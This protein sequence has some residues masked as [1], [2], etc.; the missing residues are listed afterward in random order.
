MK[1]FALSGTTAGQE[2]T[3]IEKGSPCTLGFLLHQQHH[4]LK[5]VPVKKCNPDFWPV[6]FFCYFT[7]KRTQQARHDTSLLIFTPQ[8]GSD[9]FL[10]L[11]ISL[12]A[13]YSPNVSELK[14]ADSYLWQTHCS[15][16]YSVILKN[17]N[18]PEIGKVQRETIQPPE[19]TGTNQRWKRL[20][21]I[22]KFQQ[23]LKAISGA[24]ERILE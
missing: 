20:K 4:L 2:L 11:N 15:K 7:P 16:E 24:F 14:A 6:G 18:T 5:L 21:R 12:F 10:I 9:I 3:F 22:R 13:L 23:S 1:Q 19:E 17:K 8:T